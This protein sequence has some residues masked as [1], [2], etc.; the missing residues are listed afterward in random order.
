MRNWNALRSIG[1]VMLAAALAACGGGSSSADLPQVMAAAAQRPVESC[2]YQHLY[3]TVDQVRVLRQT[4]AGP[5]WLVL[6]PTGPRRIDLLNAGA[7]LLHELGIAPLAAGHY[8]EVRLVLAPDEAS[9]GLANAV[10]PA[11]GNPASLTVPGGAQGGLKLHGDLVIS[12]G[13]TG[14]VVLQGFDPCNAVVQAGRP[15]A[16]RYLLKPDLAVQVSLS[17]TAPSVAEHRVNTTTAGGQVQPDAAKLQDGVYVIVWSSPPADGGSLGIYAQRYAADGTAVGGETRVSPA[18][19]ADQATP[20]VAG[21][22]DGGYVVTWASLGIFAQ[23]FGADGQP[24][25]APQQVNSITDL[26]Q[27]QPH[28]AALADGGYV[29][30]WTFS[31]AITAFPGSITGVAAR[32]YTAAGVPTAPEETVSSS[33]FVTDN[34]V[35]GVADGG[36][37]VAWSVTSKTTISIYTQRFDAAGARVGGITQVTDFG[38]TPALAGLSAGGYVL[39]WRSLDGFIQAQRYAADGSAVGAQVRVDPSAAQQSQPDAAALPDGGYVVT[40]VVALDVYAQRYAADSAALGG[41]TLVNTT[42]A[43]EQRSPVVIPADSGAVA[44]AWMSLNQ[45][46]DSWGIYARQFG[47]LGLP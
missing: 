32:R 3:L 35:T 13:R 38:E 37:V 25:G 29:V 31:Q 20:S 2:D 43:S 33:F 10:Q 21:L 15:S 39:T 19:T 45:D 16:P 40:W 11:G 23:R 36:Y 27:T 34:A 6:V 1:S 17:S 9:G 22:P 47:A 30:A 28:V 4:D 44:F 42:T 46:G 18:S 12:A 7:G 41:S 24:A 5:Q 14:D 8:A 26:T